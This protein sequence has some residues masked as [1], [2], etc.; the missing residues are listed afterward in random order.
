MSRERWVRAYQSADEDLAGSNRSDRRG[1][2]GL[3][4]SLG[5]LLDASNGSFLRGG[6]TRTSAATSILATVADEIVERLVE[7]GR[8]VCD[9]EWWL[10]KL[11]CA[12]R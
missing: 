5:R 6:A 3:G 11:E 9:D 10:G 7:I 2:S 1:V 8:H 4:S 12:S